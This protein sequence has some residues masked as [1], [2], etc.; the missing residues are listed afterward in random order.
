MSDEEGDVPPRPRGPDDIKI[1]HLP[2]EV[3]SPEFPERLQQVAELL[4]SRTVLRACEEADVSPTEVIRVSQ[5]LLPIFRRVRNLT[6]WYDPSRKGIEKAIIL[7]EDLTRL[8][9][10]IKTFR[11]SG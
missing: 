1:M 3:R 11:G 9:S 6:S 10:R 4:S 8:R 7:L 5:V 2:L